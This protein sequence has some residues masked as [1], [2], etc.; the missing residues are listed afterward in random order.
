MEAGVNGGLV[1]GSAISL[2]ASARLGVAR[3]GVLCARKRKCVRR[4]NK[5]A[6]NQHILCAKE[7][8]LVGRRQQITFESELDSCADVRMGV[9]EYRTCPVHKFFGDALPTPSIAA[10]SHHLPG[11]KDVPRRLDTD[12]TFVI[13]RLAR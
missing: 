13:K 9:A 7:Q 3:V 1:D 5:G 10:K 6:T 11:T 2:R 8:I 4:E 12:S